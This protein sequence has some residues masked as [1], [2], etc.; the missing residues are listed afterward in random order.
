[1]H[2]A[3]ARYVMSPAD[4]ITAVMMVILI[5]LIWVLAVPA[6][7]ELWVYM[8]DYGTHN[9]PFHGPLHITTHHI[10]SFLKFRVPYPSVE[11]ILP[12]AQVWRVGRASPRLAM[13][14][15]YRALACRPLDVRR[16]QL[17][18]CRHRAPRF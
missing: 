16:A 5:T 13:Q 7:C 12:E 3:L 2:R 17:L 18:R 9:L 1:M 8:V 15:A 11:P 6:V 4:L 10:V 14:A